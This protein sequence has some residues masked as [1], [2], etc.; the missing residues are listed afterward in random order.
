M[1]DCLR[2]GNRWTVNEL[3]QLQREFELL[4]LSVQEI[5]LKHQRSERAILFKLVSEGF[6]DHSTAFDT[7]EDYF[8]DEPEPQT[9]SGLESQDVRLYRLECAV[10]AITHVVEEIRNYFVSSKKTSKLFV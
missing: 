10:E 6:M 5:A 2:N 7:T 8:V 9:T 3:L 1:T 4:G